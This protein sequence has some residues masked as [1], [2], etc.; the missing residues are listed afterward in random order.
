MVLLDL[1][2]LLDQE[3]QMVLGAAVIDSAL[4]STL[5]L[6]VMVTTFMAP[7]I[8]KRLLADSG[9]PDGDVSAVATVTTEA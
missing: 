2:V 9:R 7:P 8:L 5:A 1:G 4:F 6:M 3:G